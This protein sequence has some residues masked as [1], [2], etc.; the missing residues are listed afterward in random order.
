MTSAEC[1]LRSDDQ[2]NGK[3][4]GHGAGRDET[5]TNRGRIM[6]RPRSVD[7]EEPTAMGANGTSTIVS[8]DSIDE[9]VVRTID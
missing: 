3:L 1:G 5:A 2:H 9:I 6:P 4:F 8:F 7:D